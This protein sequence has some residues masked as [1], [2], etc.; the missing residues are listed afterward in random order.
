M[1][2]VLLLIS[3]VLFAVVSAFSQ[4][5]TLSYQAVVRDSHNKLV[6]DTDIPVEVSVSVGGTEKYYETRTVRTNRNGVVSFSIGGDGRTW[7]VAGHPTEDLSS[8][9]GW[10]TATI[11]VTFHLSGCLGTST[12]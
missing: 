8:V 5:A 7:P 9:T 3:F 12:R 2:K 4:T 10:S 1:K 6:P 11:A